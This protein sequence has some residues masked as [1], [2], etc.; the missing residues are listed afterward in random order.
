MIKILDHQDLNNG[1]YIEQL[2]DDDGR[3]FY[4]ACGG[5]VCR[6]CDDLWMAQVYADHVC[7]DSSRA[8]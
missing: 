7:P 6:Y 2:L 8:H 3:V 4:R 1:R 5:G